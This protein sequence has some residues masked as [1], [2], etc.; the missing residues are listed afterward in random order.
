MATK[1]IGTK[2]LATKDW[3]TKDW[4]TSVAAAKRDAV[5]PALEVWTVPGA[6]MTLANGEARLRGAKC[7][8][9]GAEFFPK[10]KVCLDCWSEDIADYPL[11]AFGKLY[12]FTVVHV[13]RK[14]W[15]TPYVIAYVDLDDGVRVS[16]PLACDPTAPPAYDARVVLKVGEIG[17]TE[18]GRPIMSHQFEPVGEV[19]GGGVSEGVGSGAGG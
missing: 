15:R 9:C 12:A 19:I 5:P 14:G 18:D 1:D 10:G 6:V 16:A 17:C 4:A 3:A 13:A 7:R 2:N 11:S 8:G